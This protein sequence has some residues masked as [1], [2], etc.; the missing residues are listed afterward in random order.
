[1]LLCVISATFG[2]KDARAAFSNETLHYVISYK[3]GLVHKDAGEATLSL[4]NKGSNYSMT[5]A[6]KTKPWADKIFRV[7][8]TLQSVVSVKGLKPQSYVK[9]THEGGKYAR[10][11]IKY[12][13]GRN[14]N[15]VAKCSRYKEKDGKIKTSNR[16]LTATGPAYDMLS[17]FYYLRN[18]D[19]PKMVK[20]KTYKATVFSG[21]MAETLSI[22]SLG[23]ETIKLRDKRKVKAYHIRFKFTSDGRKKSSADMDTWI[24]ADSRSIP[25]LLEGSLPVGKVK[26]YYT[27]G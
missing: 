6:A 1:M 4:R 20:G 2:S 7:R 14:G 9:T 19:F 12:T 26:C 10:D 8:D 3:W 17:V 23:I 5:L 18:L 16:T 21:K 22:T 11:V 15:V 13:Y 25:L 24:S 27:G